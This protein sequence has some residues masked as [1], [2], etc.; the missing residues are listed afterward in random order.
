L[1]HKQETRTAI[2]ANNKSLSWLFAEYGENARKT[3]YDYNTGGN[4]YVNNPKRIIVHHTNG[5]GCS[6]I[7]ISNYH[8]NNLKNGTKGAN[9]SSVKLPNGIDSDVRYHYIIQK[10]GSIDNVRS[11]K[12]VGR[13]TLVNNIDVIHIAFCGDF[14]KNEPTTSQYAS[15]GMLIADLEGSYWN[16][17]IE[18]H[19]Q[20]KDEHTSCPGKL[21]LTELEAYTPTNTARDD[22]NWK[23]NTK[24]VFNTVSAKVCPEK[25]GFKCLGRF[26]EIT[27]YYS[28]LKQQGRYYNGTYGVDTKINGDLVNAMW[29]DYKVDHQFT[30]GAC[31]YSMI[32]KKIWIDGWSDKYGEFTCVDRWSA[33]DENDIDIRYGMWRL[34][35]NMIDWKDDKS[36]QINH[37]QSAFIYV[38]I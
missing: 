23:A 3:I 18:W 37:P 12:E 29:R 35:L 17:V 31:G 38:K 11:G 19:G 7:N 14:V 1:S 2:E 32:G 34:A 27:A 26:D 6:A 24:R 13:G 4:K 36:L 10:D 22:P 28:P 15:A 25:K 33:V 9:S 30:H 8:K 16:M 5:E 21:D 20:S